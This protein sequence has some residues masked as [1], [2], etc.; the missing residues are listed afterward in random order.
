MTTIWRGYHCS[1]CNGRI[2]EK[3]MIVLAPNCKDKSCSRADEPNHWH[4]M[5]ADMLCAEC[6]IKAGWCPLH[7]IKLNVV[8][9]CGDCYDAV[10]K[11]NKKWDAEEARA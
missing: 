1:S 9:I 2:N 3:E 4:T 8:G 10:A 5:D 7:Q 11:M 6:A